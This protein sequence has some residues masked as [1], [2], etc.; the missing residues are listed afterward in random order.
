MACPSVTDGPLRAL[1]VSGNPAAM[2]IRD[3]EDI[4]QIYKYRTVGNNSSEGNMLPWFTTN[5]R[6]E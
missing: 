6:R 1:A 2:N 3:N 4:R 5:G